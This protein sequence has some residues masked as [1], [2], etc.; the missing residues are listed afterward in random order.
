S[1][2]LVPIAPFGLDGW[3]WVVLIGAHG[4]IFV[5]WVRRALPESPRW[6]AQRGR[7]DEADRIMTEI[8]RKVGAAYGK[9]LPK[10][11]PPEP[12]VRHSKFREMWVP[13]FRKRAIMM[14]IFNVFQTIGY[15]GFANWVPTLLI[16]QG[17]MVTQSL[18]Y[19]TIIAIAAPFG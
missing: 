14:I 11:L 5:W 7:L 4:A 3:R 12:V 16:K 15:Y 13:P 19:T 8:E 9:T 2:L 10:P 18:A 6:L 1:Y 17:N